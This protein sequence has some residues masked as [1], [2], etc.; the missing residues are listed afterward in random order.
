[1]TPG[2]KLDEKS[3]V[4]RF[5]VSRTPVREA[6][7]EVVSRSLAER[8]PYRGVVVKDVSVNRI[9]SMFEAMAEI[10]AICGGLAAERMRVEE[11]NQLEKHHLN[12]NHWVE[13]DAFSEYEKDNIIFHSMI[14]NGTHNDDLVITAQDM[15]LKLAPF[16]KTQLRTRS[17]LSRSNADHSLIVEL[18]KNRNRAGVEEAM[19]Q[20]L[21]G[22]MKAV[23]AMRS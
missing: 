21:C 10:E 15:R 23:L 3:L 16:R 12:M 7:H 4:E 14:F 18:L 1:L 19:R 20:H 11:F 2:T 9:K 13:Q 17:R 6:L 22:A 8:L 5:G